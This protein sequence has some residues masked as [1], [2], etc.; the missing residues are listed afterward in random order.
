MINKVYNYMEKTGMFNGMRGI[1]AGLSGGADS[2]CLILVLKNIIRRFKPELRLAA[3]HVNHGIRGE[4]AA[5]D[6]EFSRRLSEELGVEFISHHIDIP[7]LARENGMS[8]EEAGRQERYRI[9]RETASYLSGEI[10]DGAA[11]VGGVFIAVAH[12]MDDQAET[13]LMHLIR[14]AGV[15]GLAGMEPVSGDIIRPLLCVSRS[16]IEAFLADRGQP[17]MVDATNSDDSYTRNRVRNVL[18]PLLRNEFNSNISE[19]LCGTA[20]D[21]RKLSAYIDSEAERAAQRYV[22]YT[23]CMT[24]GHGMRN[25]PESCVIR[26]LSEFVMEEDVLKERVVRNILFRCAGT[27]KNIYRCHIDAVLE[28]AL[29]Q[30]GKRIQ[31]PWNITVQKVYDELFFMINKNSDIT[32]FDM[33]IELAENCVCV[34]VDRHIYFGG[35]ICL[36]KDITFEILNNVYCNFTGNDYTKFFDYDKMKSNIHLRFKMPGDYLEISCAGGGN[37]PDNGMEGLSAANVPESAKTKLKGCRKKLKNELIDK[38]IPRDLRNQVLLLAQGQKILWAIGVRRGQSYQ[39]E[40]STERVLRVR[41]N[42]QEED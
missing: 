32:F 25:Q 24:G 17:F 10:N 1:V 23:E 12:H 11:A 14:G 15:Q 30:T 4:E 22:N 2:V 20:E 8:E 18:I 13:L 9:F 7:A 3:V 19:V 16:E 26:H 34:K 41:L 21:M 5:R 28:L 31:L 39:V 29:G 27:H 35:K 42:I 6:E 40:K 37:M 33:Q 38:K 36:L